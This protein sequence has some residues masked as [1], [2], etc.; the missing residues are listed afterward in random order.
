MLTHRNSRPALT[1][2]LWGVLGGCG[3]GGGP[4]RAVVARFDP[5]QDRYE[6]GV[7]PIRTLDDPGT[8]EGSAARF[9]ARGDFALEVPSELTPETTDEALRS[10]FYGDPGSP[11]RPDLVE[12]GGVVVA[13]DYE[14]FSLL[15]LYHHVEQAVSF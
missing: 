2:I 6:P 12:S 9:R 7:E 3:P 15:S 13:R 11:V 8:L 10:A 4:L 14:S 1:T 5:A